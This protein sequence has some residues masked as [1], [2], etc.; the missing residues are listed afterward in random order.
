[1]SVSRNFRPATVYH[2]GEKQTNEFG[3]KIGSMVED[4]QSIEIAISRMTGVYSVATDI[5]ALRATHAARTPC[6]TL[7]EDD[8]IVCNGH[9]YSIEF[10]DNLT[11]VWASLYLK[12]VR[13]VGHQS[14]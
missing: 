8:E 14:Q 6:R 7:N 4:P 3:E 10:A 13:A 2:P 11:P 5:R 12:E 1:M 9:R